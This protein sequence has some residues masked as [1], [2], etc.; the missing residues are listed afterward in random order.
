MEVGGQRHAPAALP[1]G[2][3][4]VPNVQEAGRAP[5]QVRIGAEILAP[6]WDSIPGPFIS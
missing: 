4:L 6:Q 5:R 1:L 2:K 3:G